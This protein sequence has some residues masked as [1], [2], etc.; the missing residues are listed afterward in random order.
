MR[1]ILLGL[2]LICCDVFALAD[3]TVTV[4]A[5]DG[6]PGDV[7]T[8]QVSMSATDR[9]V[10]AEFAIP[11]VEG[12]SYVTGSFQAQATGMSSSSTVVEDELRVYFYSA[13][14]NNSQLSNGSIFSFQVLLGRSPGIYKVAPSVV[15]SDV[16]GKPLS[17]EVRGA[18]FKVN[19]P[20]IEVSTDKVDFGH[21]AIR[22]T[23]RKNIGITNTGTTPLNI[24]SID[25][26]TQEIAVSE[27]SFTVSS[28]ATKQLTVSYTPS[29]T[30][31]RE[32]TL[33]IKSDAID[34]ETTTVNVISTPYSVNELMLSSPVGESDSDITVDVY[35]DNMED[36]A[37]MQCSVALPDEFTYVDDSFVASNRL[38]DMS[39]FSSVEN[40]ILT[41]YSYSESDGVIIEGS[42]KVASF[43][44]HLGSASGF[45]SLAPENVIL[46]NKDLENVLSGTTNGSIE[47]K[48]PFISCNTKIDMGKTSITDIATSVLRIKNEGKKD[49]VIDK[50]T[51]DDDSFSLNV[52]CPIVVSP[53]DNKNLEV[54]Y[55]PESSGD[56]SSNMSL[57]TNTPDDRIV[58]V[59]I[60][61]SVYEPNYIST[62]VV[63]NPDRSGSLT[64]GLSNYS[65]ISALE[66]NV[67]GLENMDIDR[68]SL[69]MTG[70]CV[71]FLSGLSYNDDGSIKVLIYSLSNAFV[72]GNSGDLF[73]F[74]FLWDK[75]SDNTITVR[76]A[77][78]LISDAN[79]KNIS[80]DI[81]KK[82][83]LT[84]I[85]SI[86]K[87]E[88]DDIYDIT[89]RY[90]G[91]D[92][93]SLPSGVYIRKGRKLVVQ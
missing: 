69:S 86:K 5:P 16:E 62:N 4:S 19:A 17:V 82:V 74:S 93:E 3:N 52:S 21:I 72:S 59:N 18:R 76:I 48:C 10:A 75:V 40:G 46:G 89:G 49:L 36:I 24:S 79:G 6:N 78:I 39:S 47:V 42:G 2:F 22:S 64:V 55:K 31:T 38:N 34:N 91:S 37:A 8:V 56:Y 50:V 83:T 15:L 29:V 57:Y 84:Q 92:V 11:I 90:V 80:G 32:M 44:L 68:A 63:L 7:V 14:L 77:D 1:K 41:L 66:M 30:G 71:G 81:E 43:K 60:V 13:D 51:F 67:Y 12:L 35:M 23:Y 9:V 87:T 65:K 27:T 45:Y 53:G 85:E 28:G 61:G 26:S 25:V 73:S 88:S 20:Q 58:D 33:T 70:R 54:R